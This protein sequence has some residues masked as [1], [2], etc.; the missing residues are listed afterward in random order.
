MEVWTSK[1]PS[2]NLT[3]P[4]ASTALLA[5]QMGSLLQERPSI[6][7]GDAQIVI[8]AII[9]IE[10]SQKFTDHKTDERTQWRNGQQLN[11]FLVIYP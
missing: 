7:E 4:E 5:I 9:E 10:G 3:F 6:L 8:D 1:I 11:Y 2:I